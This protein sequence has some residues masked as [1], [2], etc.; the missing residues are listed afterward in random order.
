MVR[1]VWVWVTEEGP[2]Q[3]EEAAWNTRETEARDLR[4]VTDGGEEEEIED[5]RKGVKSTRQWQDREGSQS[6]GRDGGTRPKGVHFCLGEGVRGFVNCAN[7]G[8]EEN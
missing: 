1:E 5:E 4:L 8:V 7:L 2:D 6:A 3:P